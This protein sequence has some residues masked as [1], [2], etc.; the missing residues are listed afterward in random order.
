MELEAVCHIIL[1]QVSSEVNK[2]IEVLAWQ[3]EGGKKQS[4]TV[5]TSKQTIFLPLHVSIEM[6]GP[7][8]WKLMG[9]YQ[10]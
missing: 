10:S 2:H 8:V 5:F 4:F 1:F 6:L 7:F 3:K 9:S